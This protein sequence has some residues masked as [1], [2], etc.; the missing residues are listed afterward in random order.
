MHLSLRGLCSQAI[1]YLELLRGSGL[2]AAGWRG[3][4]HG[5][6]NFV[7]DMLTPGRGLRDMIHDIIASTAF[8]QN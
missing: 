5:L 4:C 3:H 2:K 6:F 1:R 7:K 8:Q